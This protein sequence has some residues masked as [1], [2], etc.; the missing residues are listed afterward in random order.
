MRWRDFGAVRAEWLGMSDWNPLALPTDFSICHENKNRAETYDVFCLTD[1]LR[2]DDK[3]KRTLRTWE[4]H[5]VADPLYSDTGVDDAPPVRR[6]VAMHGTNVRTEIAFAVRVNTVR[7]KRRVSETRFV[8]D[9]EARLSQTTEQGRRHV[10]IEKGI[11]YEEPKKGYGCGDGTVPYDSVEHYGAW[12]KAGMH[13]EVQQFEGA[14][15]RPMLAD[16][17]FHVAL[18]R[19]LTGN[20]SCTQLRIT[21]VKAAGLKKVDAFSESDPYCVCA[22]RGRKWCTEYKTKVISNNANPEWHEVHV[23]DDYRD[24]EAV[25]LEVWD[26]NAWPQKDIVLGKATVDATQF[27]PDG[28]H[29]DLPMDEG[30]LSIQID[31][32]R[33]QPSSP[34]VQETEEVRPASITPKVHTPKERTP[35]TRRRRLQ[36]IETLTPKHALNRLNTTS[37]K[38]FHTLR[39][40][41]KGGSTPKLD[42]PPE[43]TGLGLPT[44]VW[45]KAPKM[46]WQWSEQRR[47]RKVWSKSMELAKGILC[48]QSLH[49]VD[50]QCPINVQIG[51]ESIQRFENVHEAIQVLWDVGLFSY[52]E[53]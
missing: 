30:T 20:P 25:D 45:R 17:R 21:L 1:L 28:W 47:C 41:W 33:A 32:I 19:E 16:P 4:E 46:R 14:G 12:Q 13:V 34:P 51:S 22:V 3:C 27:Y 29:G 38:V 26:W 49:A 43:P 36:R 39:G 6:V 2:M 31:V 10:S 50:K 24:D 15:H 11:I 18:M 53:F 40:T 8:L 44:K 48:L 9:T 5:Y 37:K 52:V 42:M 7:F 23:I 35:K